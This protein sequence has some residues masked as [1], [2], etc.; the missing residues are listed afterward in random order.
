MQKNLIYHE[1]EE[2]EKAVKLLQT[3]VK[4]F[5]PYKKGKLYTADE[6]E[7][8]DSL[9]FR[10]EKSIE[11]MLNFF[12]ALE[13]FSFA[14]ASDTLRDRLL[15]MQKLRL[16]DN[17]DFWMQARILRNKIAHTYVT[18]KLK[19]LYDEVKK[20]SGTIFNTQRKLRKYLEKAG[21]KHKK[22]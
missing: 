13:M 17:V 4:K 22:A 21:K 9:A 18:E 8:Y 14:K 6:L 10:F 1:F 2:V 5:K 19:D 3:S 20:S 15:V 7:Y 16:I 12:K 11:L